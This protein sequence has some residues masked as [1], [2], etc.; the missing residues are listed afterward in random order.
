MRN[1]IIERLL[2]HCNIIS[3]SAIEAISEA[4]IEF[5][6]SELDDDEAIFGLLD[7]EDLIKVFETIIPLL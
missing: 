3:Y 1:L 7:D 2:E 6:A 5:K 4:G